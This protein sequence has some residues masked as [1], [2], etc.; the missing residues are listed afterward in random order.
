V[1]SAAKKL[2]DCK[3]KNLRVVLE[4]IRICK[5]SLVVSEF[6]GLLIGSDVVAV[7]ETKQRATVDSLAQ[8]SRNMERTQS[9]LLQNYV[10]KDDWDA[11]QNL[12]VIGVIG[13]EYASSELL[14][15]VKRCNRTIFVVRN[16][17]KGYEL[18]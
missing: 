1:N 16:G 2:L 6:D 9:D 17:G 4:S 10:T 5:G 11:V 7:V 8:L 14:D 15:A 12:P 3:Y 13:T 18:I